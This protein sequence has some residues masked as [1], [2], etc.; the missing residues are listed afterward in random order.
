MQLD[1][2][3]DWARML[4]GNYIKKMCKDNNLESISDVEE[5]S[6]NNDEAQDL[7]YEMLSIYI[8]E[9]NSKD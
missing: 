4:V 7:L 1:S 8:Y 6:S 3:E 5:F 9:M 2:K